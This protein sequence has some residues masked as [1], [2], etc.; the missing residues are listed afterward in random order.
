MSPYKDPDK[1]RE[2][3]KLSQRKHRTSKKKTQEENK[4]E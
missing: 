2:C 3:W 4:P 1:R